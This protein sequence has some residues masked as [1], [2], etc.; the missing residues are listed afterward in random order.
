M[1]GEAVLVRS[2]AERARSGIWGQ[3]DIL[4]GGFIRK[5][6]FLIEGAS[7]TGKTTIALRL[8]LQDPLS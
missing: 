5:H 8:L 4:A 3:D 2:I 7:G 6:M 1:V